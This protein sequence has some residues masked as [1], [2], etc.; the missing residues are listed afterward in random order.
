MKLSRLAIFLLVKSVRAIRAF[1]RI[2]ERSYDKSNVYRT[3]RSCGKDLFIGGHTFVSSNTAI[4]DHCSFNGMKIYD[5]GNVSIG[6]HFHSG[7]HCRIITRYHKYD[8]LERLPYSDEYI[9]KD[10]DIGDFV[11]L[12]EGVTILGGISIGDGAIVQAYSTVVSDIPTLAIAG[13]APA[14][15]F[16]YRDEALYKTAKNNMFA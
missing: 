5:G 7:K 10:V 2:L 15:V 6:N 1:F 14:K 8:N 3:A 12:G 9:N 4:G 13:G 11:W 16:K